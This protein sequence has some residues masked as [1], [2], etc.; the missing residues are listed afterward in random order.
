MKR[1][2]GVLTVIFFVATVVLLVCA[3]LELHYTRET[4]ARELKSET[5]LFAMNTERTR[6]LAVKKA[7][8]EVKLKALSVGKTPSTANEPATQSVSE[9]FPRRPGVL[10]PGAPGAQTN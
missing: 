9:T 7:E 10:I 8:A 4:L 1:L 5:D 6:R 2:P 3:H